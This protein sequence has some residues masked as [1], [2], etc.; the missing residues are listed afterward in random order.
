[1]LDCNIYPS[2]PEATLLMQTHEDAWD[3]CV[4]FFKAAP[5][6]LSKS[7]CRDRLELEEILRMQAFNRWVARAKPRLPIMGTIFACNRRSCPPDLGWNSVFAQLEARTVS[8][9]SPGCGRSNS[10]TRQAGHGW[11]FSFT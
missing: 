11:F 3:D 10:S 1:M 7:D 6:R 5:A 4:Y 2:K 8:S 9:N